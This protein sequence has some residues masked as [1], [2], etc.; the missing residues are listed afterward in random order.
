MLT[1]VIASSRQLVVHA[2]GDRGHQQ[3]GAQQRHHCR[4]ALPVAFGQGL[5]ARCV[6][7]GH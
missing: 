1:F 7:R 2:L 5:A 3:R 6:H 4:R